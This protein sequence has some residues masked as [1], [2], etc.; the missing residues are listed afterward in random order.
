MAPGV[1]EAVCT[2]WRVA[3]A[4]IDA[5]DGADGTPPTAMTPPIDPAVPDCPNQTVLGD[6]DRAAGTT[7]RVAAAG[8]DAL[9]LDD[10]H[11]DAATF[12]ETFLFVTCTRWRR[13]GRMW[14][15]AH[16]CQRGEVTVPTVIPPPTVHQGFTLAPSTRPAPYDPGTDAYTVVVTATLVDGL[17]WGT[18]PP[19]WTYVDPADGDLHGELARGAVQR[20]NRSIRGDRRRRA[21]PVAVTVPTIVL[22]TDPDRGS[23]MSPIRPVR[24]TRPWRTPVTV[25][26]TLSTAVAWGTIAADVDVCR[27]DDGDVHGDVERGVMHRR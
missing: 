25:T 7:A 19:G 6:G 26:A 12:S 14:S 8:R 24:M 13:R 1:T 4:G 27:P 21:P 22:A 5:G 20:C 2:R 15:R 16:V 11:A 3:P 17:S 23:P 18:M 9:R 10:R